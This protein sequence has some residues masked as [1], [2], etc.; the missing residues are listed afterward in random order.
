MSIKKCI[1]KN[2]QEWKDLV[3]KNNG[4]EVLAEQEWYRE[5]FGDRDE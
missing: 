3:I 1:N 4:N 5:G 2:S